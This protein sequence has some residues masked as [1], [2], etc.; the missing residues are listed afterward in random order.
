MKLD[1]IKYNGV[2]FGICEHKNCLITPDS[3]T[4][5]MV[6][7][8]WATKKLETVLPYTEECDDFT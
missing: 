5:L 8:K 4:S 7:P 1:D 6:A 2:S 3:G